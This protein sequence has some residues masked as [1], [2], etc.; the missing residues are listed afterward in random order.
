M[1][2]T[3]TTPTLRV[4]IPKTATQRMVCI[5]FSGGADGLTYRLVSSG[6]LFNSERTKCLAVSS[7]NKKG[8]H[9]LSLKP[10]AKKLGDGSQIFALTDDG[11]ILFVRAHDPSGNP[12]RSSNLKY[13]CSCRLGRG[14]PRALVRVSSAGLWTRRVIRKRERVA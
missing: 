10:C 3:A 4:K 8:E 1:F 9:H 7:P 12:P 13:G 11:D 2:R 6:L 5:S 14:I